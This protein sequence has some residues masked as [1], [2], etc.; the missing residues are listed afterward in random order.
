MQSEWGTLGPPSKSTGIPIIARHPRGTWSGVIEP[1]FTERWLGE[2]RDEIA[3]L[4][5]ER[6]PG[7]HQEPLP[8]E[9]A[10]FERLGIPWPPPQ[11][12]GGELFGVRLPLT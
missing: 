1:A 9:Q 10:D 4:C 11:N 12:G 2:K 5:S 7:W 3:H 6:K 8:L